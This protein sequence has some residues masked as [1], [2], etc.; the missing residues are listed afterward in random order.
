VLLS[1]AVL[2]VEAVFG[3]LCLPVSQKKRGPFV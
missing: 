1:V 2:G 3:G